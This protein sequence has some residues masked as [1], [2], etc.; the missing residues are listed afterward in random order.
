MTLTPKTLAVPLSDADT[1]PC[2][3]P[4]YQSGDGNE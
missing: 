1:T 2:T 3:S 4:T